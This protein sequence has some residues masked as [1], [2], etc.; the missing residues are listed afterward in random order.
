M[1]RALLAAGALALVACPKK[2]PELSAPPAD[3]V[4]LDA[5]LALAETNRDDLALPQA[6]EAGYLVTT[7]S[8]AIDTALANPLAV[9]ELGAR[10]GAALDVATNPAELFD[11]LAPI[12]PACDSTCARRKSPAAV[13]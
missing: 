3:K 10:L 13:A 1:R 2:G 12:D 11:A 6:E 9:P 8:G 4:P 5:L 7:R